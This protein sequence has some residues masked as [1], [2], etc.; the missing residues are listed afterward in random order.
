[1]IAALMWINAALDFPA[2]TGPISN[3]FPGAQGSDFSWVLG[4][5]VA[6][7]VYWLLARRQVAAEAV[8]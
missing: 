7:A 1:M 2:Y 5:V 3:H 4:I 6:S 8:R